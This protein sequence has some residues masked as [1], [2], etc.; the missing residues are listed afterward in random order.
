MIL[1]QYVNWDEE[2][3]FINGTLKATHVVADTLPGDYT[4]I[5]SI[6]SWAKYGPGLIGSA[7]NFKDWKCLQR[8]IRALADALTG[9]EYDDN[10]NVFSPAEKLIVCNYL[11]TRVPPAR[12]AQTVTDAGERMQI[13]IDFD[14]NNRRARGNWQTG[15]GRIQV[16]R[17]YLFN[18]VGKANGLTVLNDV[19][20]DGLLEM[21]EGGIEGTVED[22]IVGLNDFLLSRAATPYS[23]TGLSTRSYPMIDGSED[24][25]Q[26]VATA[27]AAIAS[28]GT[29]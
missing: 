26:T 22:G 18:K 5:S 19:V 24:N 3:N 7:T 10:W 25:M 2:S 21:Y 13:S 28:N 9:G 15:S 23:A 4:D 6:T 17:I 29:Y 11:L 1:G 27:L 20:R 14:L 16:M 12:F 8:E